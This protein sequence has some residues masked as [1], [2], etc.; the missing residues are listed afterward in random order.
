MSKRKVLLESLYF[1]FRPIAA[2]AL[3]HGITAQEINEIVKQSMVDVCRER[4]GIRGRPTN[5]SRVAAMTNLTR[6]DVARLV[7]TPLPL[8]EGASRNPV[9][10]LI[11]VWMREWHEEN[12]EPKVLRTDIENEDFQLLCWQTNTQLSYQTMIKELQRLGVVECKGH[13]ITLI[14]PGFIPGDTEESSLPFLGEDAA[15][16][17]DTIDHNL[18]AESSSERRY[19]RKLSFPGLTPEGMKILQE[20]AATAGQKLLEKTDAIVAEHR[21]PEVDGEQRFSGMG[22]YV[23]DLS[24][25]DKKLNDE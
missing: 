23:F 2:I 15:A 6:V 5:K 17:V 20:T 8:A 12:G 14:Q 7:D 3:R 9:N 1:L 18:Q 10:R 13:Q 24:N 25:P 4:Y 19:Q 21:A 16:L 22:I 11:G